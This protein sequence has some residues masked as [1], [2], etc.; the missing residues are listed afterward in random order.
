M[1]NSVRFF[2]GF[3]LLV[4]IMCFGCGGGKPEAEIKA[5]AQAMDKAKSFHAEELATSNWNEAMQAL[6]QGEAAVKEGK[7]SKTYFLRAKSRFEKTAT[8]AKS[9]Q[10][11]LAK[12]VSEMQMATAQRFSKVKAAI[13]KG[14]VKP[15]VLIQVNPI[16]AEAEVGTVSVSSLVSQGDYLKARTT[17]KEVQLKVYNAELILAGKKPLS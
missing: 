9:R 7:P 8:I 16:V 17:A 4:L 14:G 15:K 11:T 13:E 10:D 2:V 12:E 5:A 1:K 3:N 6:M